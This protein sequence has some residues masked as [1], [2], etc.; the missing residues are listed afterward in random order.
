MA[1][2]DPYYLLGDGCSLWAL[3]NFW[4]LLKGGGTTTQVDV[5]GVGVRVKIKVAG[6]AQEGLVE[7]MQQVVWQQHLPSKT[8]VISPL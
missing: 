6:K 7:A 1:C 2:T 4:S 3:R 5:E 8:A